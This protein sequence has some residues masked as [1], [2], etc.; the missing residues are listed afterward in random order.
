VKRALDRLAGESFD[1][2]VVGGGIYGACAAF[3]GAARGLRV[4]L[5][6]RDDFGSGTSSQS[7]KVVH[8]GL[9][10][11]QHLDLR[12]TLESIAERRV[13][14]RIAPHLVQPLA[15]A[16]P[17]YGH[18][19]R[20]RE[21]VAIG[22]WL[23]EL[24]GSSRGGSPDPA[25]RIPRGRLL[26]RAEML[27]LCPG[28]DARGLT[29]GALWWDA[30]TWSSE[31]LLLAFLAAAD[32]R[33]A[34]L[35]NHVEATG[36]L[37]E[38]ERSTRP[39]AAGV[40]LRDRETGREIA[41]R[42]RSVLVCAG[43][44]VDR[45]L[46]RAGVARRRPL[47][48]L[49]KALNLVVRRLFPHD[50]ALGVAGRSAFRDRDAIVQAGSR[51]FFLVPWQDVTLVGTKH[52]AWEGEPESFAVDEADVRAFLAEVNDALP[53]AG[54]VPD[55]VVGVYAGMLPRT[56]GTPARGEVQLQKS[57]AFTDHGREDGVE[58]LFSVV[59]VKWTTARA[60]AAR[61]VARIAARLGN[62][63]GG[64]AAATVRAV[65][66]GEIEDVAKFLGRAEDE[67]V[68][69]LDAASFRHLLRA[70]GRG[71]EAVTG[72]VA[73]DPAL[74]RRLHAASPVV[75]AEIVHAARAEMALHLDDVL[76][77]R[78]ALH[79]ARPL[80]RAA[81]DAAAALAARELGWDAARTAAEIER[82]AAALRRFTVL[83]EAT[84]RLDL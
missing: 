56:P 38:G 14:L 80:G 25:R 71:V 18:G 28:L 57:C 20:G 17:L 32:A 33:G 54:V 21:A 44:W 51:L 30:Q 58:G 2:A 77:R 22:L 37:L 65:A 69:G 12:R 62:E 47:F 3:E 39:R 59:G 48:G 4:A 10:Y 68:P 49:S 13:L 76:L 81:L 52:L 24:A 82:A 11:L 31:R 84:A 7:L 27:A 8:G 72:L 35:A 70:H 75:G 15:C 36:L 73:A 55:D 66:G 53:A 43:P 46:A 42:A 50:T 79:L 29:A 64:A 40:A 60:V 16:M 6:E 9:R 78:T 1:L 74:G 26:S 45:V 61:S 5:V 63:G 83:P 19:V 23:N 41:L 67:R 34:A